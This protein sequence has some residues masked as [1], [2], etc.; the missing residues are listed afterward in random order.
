MTKRAVLTMTVLVLL[1]TTACRG[2]PTKPDR[3]QSDAAT[4]APLETKE[5][6]NREPADKRDLLLDFDQVLGLDLRN[7]KASEEASESDPRIDALLRERN[8]ARA[9]RDFAAADRIRDELAA[10]GVRIIDTPDGARWTRE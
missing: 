2:E 8:E 6:K 10:E 1:A 3:G 4:P 7:A 5:A 9:N